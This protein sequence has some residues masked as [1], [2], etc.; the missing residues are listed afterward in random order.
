MIYNSIP[1]EIKVFYDIDDERLYFTDVYTEAY[2]KIKPLIDRIDN[3]VKPFK[4]IDYNSKVNKLKYKDTHKDKIFEIFDLYKELYDDI[5]I[6]TTLLIYGYWFSNIVCKY[7]NL[8]FKANIEKEYLRDV[9]YAHRKCKKCE[10]DNY[11]QIESRMELEGLIQ[12]KFIYRIVLNKDRDYICKKCNIFVQRDIIKNSQVFDEKYITALKTIPYNEYLETDH[13]KILRIKK[14]K[15][16]GFQCQL[17]KSK[18]NLNVHHI[19][20]ENRG[21]EKDEDL[22]VLCNECH[23]EIHGIKVS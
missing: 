10:T 3:Y 20:Y 5:Y 4:D 15:E 6:K 19:T 17:C 8:Y 13:W 14:L 21:C 9:V 18:E 12:N 11:I 1:N 23:M 16:S 22:M 7:F 2:N